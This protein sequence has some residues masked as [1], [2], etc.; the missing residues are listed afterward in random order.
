MS[1]LKTILESKL[2]S[3]ITKLGEET[4]TKLSELALSDDQ[5]TEISS[6]LL[7]LAEAENNPIIIGKNKD[8]WHKAEFKGVLDSFDASLRDHEGILET[9]PTNTKDKVKE[10]LKT[11]KSKYESLQRQNEELTQKAKD[12]I[13]DAEL[14]ALLK[15]KEE[16]VATLKTT[17]I[18][19]DSIKE[20]ENQVADYKREIEAF[21]KAKVKDTIVLAA[22][23]TGILTDIPAEFAD[24]IVY[25]ATKKYL[26]NEEFNVGGQAV[27]A[28]IV[29]DPKTKQVVIRNASDESLAVTSNGQILT[30]DK[31]VEDVLVKSNLNKKSQQQQPT[32]VTPP[33]PTDNNRNTFKVDP[34]YF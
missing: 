21:K 5:V 26:E 18:P 28:K 14:K 31:L 11:Y 1:N 32:I 4:L 24:D 9:V 8:A 22:K 25:A 6:K 7:G 2:G 23:N 34:K 19:K 13:S 16:E 3:D 15:A 30:I 17:Y 29:I 27:K 12:G 10:V 20:Y 33:I